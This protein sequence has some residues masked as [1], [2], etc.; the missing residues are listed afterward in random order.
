[1]EVSKVPPLDASK[2]QAGT[3]TLAEQGSP[4]A[5][6][7]APTAD[8]ADIR[9]LGVASA[10]MILLAEVRAGL[11]MPG[12]AATTRVPVQAARELVDLFLQRLPED[13]NDVPAWTSALIRVDA[14]FQ[15]SIERALEV[16][17]R[18]R[19]VPTTVVDAVKETRALFVAALDDNP[20]NPL[21][22]RPEWLGLV[23][24]LQRFRRRR[25]NARRRMID[26]DYSSGSLD[27]GWEPPVT[28]AERG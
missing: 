17:T 9:P 24:M 13:P 3:S 25:R 21:F 28:V 7:A 2:V 26:P 23:P 10:L 6:P 14:T 18:W 19:D 1:M 22:L 11:D 27:E 5:A 8:S 16:V 4:S 12:D 20:Q 15:S